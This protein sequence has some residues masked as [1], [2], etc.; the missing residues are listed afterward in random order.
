MPAETLTEYAERVLHAESL[1]EKLRVSASVSP[2]EIV[3]GGPNPRLSDAVEPGRPETLRL[4]SIGDRDRARFPSLAQL[5]DDECR[6][7]LFHFFA[8]HELMAAELM[9]LALLKFP[10]APADFRAGLLATMREEQLHTRWYV[11]RMQACGVAFGSHPLSRFFWD[12]VA[13]MQSPLDYVTRL[14]LTFEQANLDYTRHY[15]AALREVGDEV[16]ARLLDRIYRDEIQH[17]GYG[18]RWFRQWKASGQSDW[19]AYRSALIFPLSPSRAKGNGTGFNADG[20]L[21]AGLDAGFVEELAIFERSKGRTPRVFWFN[22]DAEDAM[23]R[24]LRGGGYQPTRGVAGFISDLEPLA[25]FLSRRDDVVLLRRAPRRDYLERLRGLGFD[26]PEIEVVAGETALASDSLTRQRKLRELRPWAWDFRSAALFAPLRSGL[27]ASGPPPPEWSEPVRNLFSK[28]AQMTRWPAWDPDDEPG[29]PW[30][31]HPCHSREVMLTARAAIRNAFG[32]RRAIAEK[33]AFAAA[34]RGIRVDS[35]E[36]LSDRRGNPV[37]SKTAVAPVDTVIEPWADRVLD[38]SVQYEMT[39]DGLRWLGFCRQ[40]LDD[41]G[42]Y[43]GTVW[44]PKFCRGLD[45]DLARFLMET[46]LARYAE[47]GPLAAELAAWLSEA[48]YFG[49]VGIDAFVHR[50]E[51]GRLRHRVICEINPRYTMGRLTWELA[52]KVSPGREVRFEIVRKPALPTDDKVA[53][54]ARGRLA[55]GSSVTLT[56][57]ETATAWVAQLWVH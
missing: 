41:A 35:D 12:A 24:G 28:T 33:A 54:D 9:A 40:V 36:T 48:G 20:R 13:P 56:D 43:L 52:Q 11:E 44:S 30:R 8:N 22:P 47:G 16:S 1:E 38:F 29:S 50:D 4:R 42:R 25:L 51:T 14:S 55:A 31:S 45:D 17:V 19:D 10:D 3:G 32:D 53:L 46:V 57:I 23:A 27:P 37:S 39:P 2:D 6:G 49:P 15:A 5:T 7:R 34:G 26:L 18:L 21:A